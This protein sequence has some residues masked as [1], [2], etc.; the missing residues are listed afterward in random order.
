MLPDPDGRKQRL[1]ATIPL[2]RL[3]VP[4]DIAPTIAFLAS[5]EARYT[6]GANYVVDGGRTVV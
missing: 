6:T 4:E 2:G 5:D 3:G 1:K